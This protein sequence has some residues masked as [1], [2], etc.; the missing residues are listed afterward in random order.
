MRTTTPAPVRG[1]VLLGAP[2]E[3]V[4][5]GAASSAA[6]FRVVG[7]RSRAAVVV[8]VVAGGEGAI[9][10]AFSHGGH[11]GAKSSSRL[12][13]LGGDGEGE[14]EGGEN[15]GARVVGVERSSGAF[16]SDGGD[17]ERARAENDPLFPPG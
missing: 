14:A 17:G 1:S 5:A 8:T 9:R 6:D 13:V 3:E 16:R 2:G 4:E 12:V 15:N 10:G 11:G 7:V